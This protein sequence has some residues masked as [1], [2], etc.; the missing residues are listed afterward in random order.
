MV[1]RLQ[2][3]PPTTFCS[4]FC[5]SSMFG[6]CGSVNRRRSITLNFS[7]TVLQRREWMLSRQ[8][9][10]VKRCIEAHSLN[11]F[12]RGKRKIFIFWVCVCS[13]SCPTRSAH[14]LYCHLWPRRLYNIFPRYLIKGAIFELFFWKISHFKKNWERYDQKRI[15]VLMYITCYS[16]QFLMQL[17]LSQQIFEKSSNIKFH[18]N[19]PRGS[20]IV[21]FGQTRRSQ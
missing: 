7:R 8:A 16:C 15:L 13:L 18:E 3:R 12:C 1:R 11:H 14:A 5:L 9:V 6:W 21:P 10:Y 17:E 20:L 19:L 4:E 2:V